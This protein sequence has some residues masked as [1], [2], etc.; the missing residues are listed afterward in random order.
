MDQLPT[1]LY[2][3]LVGSSRQEQVCSAF[4]SSWL[5]SLSRLVTKKTTMENIHPSLG[6]VELE[7]S[8]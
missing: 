7:V 6:S 5:G 4:C 1:T 8:S 3:A 2:A